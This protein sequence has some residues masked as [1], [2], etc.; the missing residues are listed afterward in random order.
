[1]A[2]K[3]W[4]HN[5]CGSGHRQL[6]QFLL[7]ISSKNMALPLLTRIFHGHFTT[8]Y[9]LKISLYFAMKYIHL[10]RIWR[11]CIFKFEYLHVLTFLLRKNGKFLF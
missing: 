10:Y 3:I 8:Y 9:D 7:I 5:S 6:I 2:G 1:M 11:F 4:R